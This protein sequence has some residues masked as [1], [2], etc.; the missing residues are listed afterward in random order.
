MKINWTFL[1]S[2]ASALAGVAGTVITPVYGTG[3]GSSVQGILQA[4]SGLLIAIGAWHVN[5]VAA[6]QARAKA[7]RA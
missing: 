1:A 4:V 7:V 6:A 5:G 2:I 3:L